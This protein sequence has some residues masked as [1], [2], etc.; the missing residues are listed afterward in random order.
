M[1]DAPIVIPLY[2]EG[3]PLAPGEE[4]GQAAVVLVGLALKTPFDPQISTV[5]HARSGSLPYSH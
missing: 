4:V 5:S 2:V 1:H 3:H